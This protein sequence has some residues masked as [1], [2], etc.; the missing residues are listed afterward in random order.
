MHDA[1]PDGL[2][3]YTNAKNSHIPTEDVCTGYGKL[4]STHDEADTPLVF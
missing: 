2:K 1:I 3:V 4:K